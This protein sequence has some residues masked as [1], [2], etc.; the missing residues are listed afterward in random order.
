MTELADA[1]QQLRD[2]AHLNQGA[3]AAV[4]AQAQIDF[5]AVRTWPESTMKHEVLRRLAPTITAYRAAQLAALALRDKSADAL[6]SMTN[7]P[8]PPLPESNMATVTWSVSDW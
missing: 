5:D 1:L 2:D 8:A 7:S 4:L 6:A 3:L